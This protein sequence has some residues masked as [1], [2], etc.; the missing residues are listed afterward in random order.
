MNKPAIYPRTLRLGTRGS[1]LARWQAEWVADQLR[2]L[3]HAVEILEI[4]TRG[5]VRRVSIEEIGTRGVF[6]KE[7]QRA[8]LA[9]DI[10]LGVHSL[11][12]LPTEVVDGLVLAAVPHRESPADVL[13][14][15]SE[16]RGARTDDSLSVLPLNARVGSGSLRRQAQ[17]RHLRP[18]LIVADVRGNVDTR[19]RKLDD[20]EFD[21]IVLAEAGLRRLGL[22]DRMALKLPFELMMPAVGQGALAIECR[23]AD[24]PTRSILTPLEDDAT[25]A[26]VSAERALLEH[27]RG[28]CMAPVGALARIETGQLRLSAVVLSADGGRR[29]AASDGDSSSNAEGLGRRV[30][31]NLLNQGAAQIIAASRDG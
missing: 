13:V 28:G 8:I 23:A 1:K 30:A 12:D 26:A 19:L 14:I 24:E 11:K 21:A 17:L 4:V 10:D 29:L 7:I 3:G 18:D 31:E 20:G 5:D 25:R 9:G 2:R 16:R 6:T 22:T 15:R 27:L